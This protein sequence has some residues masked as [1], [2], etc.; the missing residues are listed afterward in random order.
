MS[1]KPGLRSIEFGFSAAQPMEPEPTVYYQT[2]LVGE[3]E[4]DWSLP[5]RKTSREFTGLVPGSYVFMV[6]RYDRYGRIGS[7]ISYPFAVLPPWYQEWP[8]RVAASAALVALAWGIYRW[9]IR[10]LRAQT[11]RLNRLV[12]KRTRELELSNTAKS[13][14]LENISHEIRN[15]LNGIVGLSRLLHGAQLEPKERELA[16]SLQASAE[17]LRRVSEDVLDLSKAE[18]GNLV[19]A[20][21]P[22]S[23]RSVLREI[24]GHYMD[25]ARQAGEKIT[26]VV[27]ESINDHF[28]GDEKKIRTIVS[29]FVANAVKYAPGGPIEIRADWT[30]ESDTGARFVTQVFI[31]VTDAGPGVPSEEQEVIFQKFVRGTEAK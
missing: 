3:E 31:A 15:P 1:A 5:Q 30:D 19:L 23:L 9:R 2:R 29:N 8:A 10:S 24:A 26:L 21:D 18:F 7:P 28:L 12:A 4:Q 25:S 13:E 6:R 17:H 14:F 11:E 16:Q 27:N 20:N 22:F